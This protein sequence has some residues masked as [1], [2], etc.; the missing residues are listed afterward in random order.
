[1][2]IERRTKLKM[3]RM[4]RSTMSILK[5]LVG[6]ITGALLIAIS[7]N[8]LIMPYGLLAGGVGGLALIGKY[9]LDIPLYIGIFVLNIPIFAWGLKELDRKFILYSLAGTI[10]TIIAIPTLKPYIPVPRLD[11]FLAAVFS[12]IVGGV[13][14]GIFFKVGASAGGTDII[15]MIMKKKKNISVGA[16]SFYCN[17]GVL[18]FSLFFFDLKIALYT[19]VSM[20][21]GGKMTDTVIEGLNKNKSVMIISEKNEEIAQRIMKDVH[22][23]VTFLEGQGAFSGGNKKVINC[24]VSH[25]EIAKVKEVVFETDS[26]AFIFF[27]E[28]AEVVGKGFTR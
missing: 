6:M 8:A 10:V 7:Y 2:K 11:L 15:S 1:M 26:K 12:G 14:G 4:G 28:T 17:I 23:G 5:K 3:I 13:G 19:A 21:V 27:T 16:V 20:W 18:A 24:V 22:R 9:V 25:F